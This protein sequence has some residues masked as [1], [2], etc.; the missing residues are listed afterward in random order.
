M[1][2]NHSYFKGFVGTKATQ[3]AAAGINAVN[4]GMLTDTGV[5]ISALK[6]ASAPNTLGLGTYGFF[7]PKAGWTSVN[8]ASAATTSGQPFYLGAAPVTPNDKIGP[9]HGGYAET[10]KSKLI[11]PKYI[12][13][14]AK[15]ED[16][17]PEQ[18]IVHVGNTNF[19]SAFGFDGGTLVGGTGY[20]T[21]GSF[22]NVATTGGTGTG[23]TVDVTIVGGI[24]TSIVENQVGSGYTIG[25]TITVS[26]VPTL[27][28]PTTPATINI[29]NLGE[30]SCEFEFLC[31]E[32]YKLDIN[33][34]GNPVLR[35][36][37]HD[38]YRVLSA[39]TGCCPEGTVDP[40]AVDSTLVM[41]D[42]AKQI[43]TSPYLKDFVRP[44][45]FDEAGLLWFATAEEAVAAGWPA[46]AIFDNYVSTGHTAGALAGL[47]IVGAY[48]DTQ[49]G[50]CSFQTSDYF[51]KEVVKIR[52]SLRDDSGEACNVPDLCISTECC[53]YDG[54]GFG[55]TY[56]RELILCNSYLQKHFHSDQRLREINQGDSF[57]TA[58]DRTARYTKYII[59]HKV[60]RPY[61]HSGSYSEEQYTNAIYV[62]SGVTAT[63]LE[64]FM[65]AW[66]NGAG[67]ELAGQITAYGME[68][69]S[70]VACT[71]VALPAAP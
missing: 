28:T 64:A 41:L 5:H 69:Y 62:P 37:N 11:N 6:N 52:V 40:V 16:A 42:W 32:T 31:G 22:E 15:F 7:D 46:T 4:N 39:Y 18:A 54:E 45:V 66:L 58:I 17:A 61:N 59:Q 13:R 23:L 68:A 9:F 30:Q 43:I 50:N 71:P 47:R 1:Y 57:F 29:L 8:T 34:H 38:A 24:V 33:L 67:N 60:P 63:E 36:L 21:D 27:G 26:D 70:H 2:F 19:Q 35:V 3:S 44:I 55:E 12:T 53:G 56:L 10:D 20:P 49:F 25:D 48:I 51:N 65:L 14:F